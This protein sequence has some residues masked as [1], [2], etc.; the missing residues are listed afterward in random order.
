VAV[1]VFDADVLIAF[2]NSRDVNHEPAVER[3]RGSLADGME[4]WICAVTLSEILVGPIRAG[5]AEVVER[6]LVRLG[7]VTKPVDAGLARRAA[8]VRARTNLRLPDAYVLATAIQAEERGWDD[9]RL[10]TFD[11]T[12]QT[13][14]GRRDSEG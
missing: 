10:E 1:T 3:V 8:A 2:L 5:R 4:R 14:R 7:I 11:E 13:A 6:M 12:L 9:V